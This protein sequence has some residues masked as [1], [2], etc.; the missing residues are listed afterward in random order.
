MA[1]ALALT[2]ASSSAE[3]SSLD[4]VVVVVAAG[5]DTYESMIAA[6]AISN[7]SSVAALWA[8]ATFPRKSTVPAHK[9][10]DMARLLTIIN[11]VPCKI[12]FYFNLIQN[13]FLF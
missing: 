10:Y 8:I 12:N 9:R 7:S 6:S 11:F 3:T 13:L 5:S 1:A 2:T 4:M